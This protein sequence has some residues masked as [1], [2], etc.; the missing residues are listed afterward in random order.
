MKDMKRADRMDRTRAV[1]LRRRAAWQAAMG[2]T[3]LPAFHK[4]ANWSLFGCRGCPVCSPETAKDHAPWK[5]R[6]NVR[7]LIAEDLAKG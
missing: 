3:P 2:D 7:R 4:A 6:R 5:A 1:I